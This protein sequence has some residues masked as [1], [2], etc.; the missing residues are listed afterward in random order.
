MAVGD[1]PRGVDSPV[2][3]AAEVVLGRVDLDAVLGQLGHDGLWMWDHEDPTDVEDHRLNRMQIEPMHLAM[4]ACRPRASLPFCPALVPVVSGPHVGP[5]PSRVGHRCDRFR[6]RHVERPSPRTGRRCERHGA[7][8]DVQLD[9]R[10]RL[11]DALV[12]VVR[13][14]ATYERLVSEAVITARAATEHQPGPSERGAAEEELDSCTNQLVAVMEGYPEL[15]TDEQFSHLRVQLTETEDDVAAA[16]RYYNGR[17]R[18]YNTRR[19]TLP[20]AALA[21]PLGFA[22]SEYFQID[23]EERDAPRTS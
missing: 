23:R 10:H 18:L 12:S 16:R 19:E 5:R 17:V 4:V 15:R 1:S 20:W 8:I 22:E 11:V 2:V 13:A 21:G 7:Q 14:G 6:D 3:G 9:R